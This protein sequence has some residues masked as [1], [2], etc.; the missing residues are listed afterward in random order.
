MSF[1]SLFSAFLQLDGE[2]HM[3]FSCVLESPRTAE[4]PLLEDTEFLIEASA[5][6]ACK[7]KFFRAVIPDE[8]LAVIVGE[9]Q[10]SHQIN[11]K[12]FCDEDSNLKISDYRKVL[13]LDSD[14]S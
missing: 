2:T 11:L 13:Q 1:F 12:Y 3:L 6:L 7:V 10:K 8:R 14:S 5:P 9:A 4:K